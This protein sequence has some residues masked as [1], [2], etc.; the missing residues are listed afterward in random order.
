LEGLLNERDSEIE[1]LEERI[2]KLEEEK[3]NLEEQLN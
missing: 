2:S 1:R 3:D